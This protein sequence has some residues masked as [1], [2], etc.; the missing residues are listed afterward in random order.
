MAAFRAVAA[1]SRLLDDGLAHRWCTTI[2][3]HLWC[4]CG[5]D[6]DLQTEAVLAVDALCGSAIDCAPALLSAA[7]A[8]LDGTRRPTGEFVYVAR[9]YDACENLIA[10]CIRAAGAAA[11]AAPLLAFYDDP[12]PRV[13]RVAVLAFCVAAA[14]GEALPP[15]VVAR[16]GSGAVRAAVCETDRAVP[17]HCQFLLLC[18]NRGMPMPAELAPALAERVAGWAPPRDEVDA[19]VRENVAAVLCMI[20]KATGQIVIGGDVFDKVIEMMPMEADAKLNNWAYVWLVWRVRAEGCV[21]GRIMRLLCLGFVEGFEK[22]LLSEAVRHLVWG[23]IIGH[24][25]DVEGHFNE[26]FASEIQWKTFESEME[27]M[28]ESIAEQRPP[29]A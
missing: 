11:I 28:R 2:A 8:T 15:D 22:L 26:I 14:G 10:K 3:S 23:C 24:M 27:R 12:D 19:V 25:D 6:F 13:R 7:L 16:I 5:D 4:D 29:L 20:E 1:F 18:L 9:L 17:E 21:G